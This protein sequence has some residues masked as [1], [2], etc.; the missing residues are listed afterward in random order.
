MLAGIAEIRLSEE[1]RIVFDLI[2]GWMFNGAT[3]VAIVCLIAL[4]I[5]ATIALIRMTKEELKK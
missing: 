3:V 4:T 5:Y 1:A 2:I